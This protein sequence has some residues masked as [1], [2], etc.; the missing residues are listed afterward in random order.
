MGCGDD[1]TTPDA[2]VDQ[3]VDLA[4][5]DASPA[6]DPECAKLDCSQCT[7]QAVSQMC[8]VVQSGNAGAACMAFFD[9]Q[10]AGEC[11]KP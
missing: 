5:G 11:G 4:T 3:A 6:I 8:G 7:D 1:D 2:N 9:S 10:A